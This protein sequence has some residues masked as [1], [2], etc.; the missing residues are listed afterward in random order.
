MGD[1]APASA[2]AGCAEGPGPFP[3]VLCGTPGA[4]ERRT[5]PSSPSGDVLPKE[6]D[7]AVIYMSLLD[8]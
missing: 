2:P 3:A 5:C 7:E 1:A 6:N 4:Q 8:V